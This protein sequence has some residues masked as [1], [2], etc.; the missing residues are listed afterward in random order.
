VFTYDLTDG[1]AND[2]SHNSFS[3]QLLKV[4]TIPMDANVVIATAPAVKILLDMLFFFIISSYL[5]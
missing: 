4:E 3:E 5:D 1:K 2:L